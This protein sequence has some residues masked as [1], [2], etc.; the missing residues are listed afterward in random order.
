MREAPATDAN[1]TK[2][3]DAETAPPK[4]KSPPPHVMEILREYSDSFARLTAMT[5]QP[6]ECIAGGLYKQESEQFFGYVTKDSSL[7]NDIE[8]FSQSS[9]RERKFRGD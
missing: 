9:E 4:P 5:L 7:P 3:N 1:A 6:S 8:N 2:P